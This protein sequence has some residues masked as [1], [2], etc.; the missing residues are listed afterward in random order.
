M[1]DLRQMV[2]MV[3]N[4]GNPLAMLQQMNDPRA[5]QALNMLQNKNPAQLQQI[6]MNM[7]KERG[8]TVEEVA[9]SLGIQIP[10]QR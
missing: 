1:L 7:A 8:T 3:M 4:G 10:S 2:Q 5:M 9:R 6:A